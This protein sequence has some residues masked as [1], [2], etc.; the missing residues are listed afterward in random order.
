MKNRIINSLLAI[1]LAISTSVSFGDTAYS[2][3]I[4]PKTKTKN[5]NLAMSAGAGL[6]TYGFSGWTSD[7]IDNQ[8]SDKRS[9]V[10]IGALAAIKIDNENHRFAGVY[11]PLASGFAIGTDV[12]TNTSINIKAIFGSQYQLY[13]QTAGIPSDVMASD[14]HY[15]FNIQHN[16]TVNNTLSLKPRI[17]IAAKPANLTVNGVDIEYRD[18]NIGG[19]LETIINLSSAFKIRTGLQYMHTLDTQVSSMG[20]SMNLPV[21]FGLKNFSFRAM[22]AADYYFTENF[23]ATLSLGSA[24]TR[25]GLLLP[26]TQI[27]FT[28][29]F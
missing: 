29:S 17:V 23:S 2:G 3:Y 16:Y 1:C 28:Y 13:K 22:L 12:T 7:F 15:E 5:Q 10:T 26:E 4:P 14:R 21:F 27:Q 19:G 25:A 24:Q 18:I 6:F 8:F 20:H 9:N 11:F